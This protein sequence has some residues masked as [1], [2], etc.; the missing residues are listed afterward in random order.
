MKEEDVTDAEC[1]VTYT[2]APFD[3]AVLVQNTDEVSVTFSASLLLIMI[4]P[5][6]PPLVHSVNAVKEMLMSLLVYTA[7]PPAV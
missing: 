2:S 5:P 3:V 6:H 1:D 4:P 7:P